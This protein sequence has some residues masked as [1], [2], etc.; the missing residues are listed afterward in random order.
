MKEPGKIAVRGYQVSPVRSFWDPEPSIIKNTLTFDTETEMTP[1][2]RLRVGCY[3]H[4]TKGRTHTG[5]FYDNTVLGSNETKTLTDY[6]KANH[7]NLQTIVGFQNFLARTAR[8]DETAIVGFNLPFD[9]S[10][11][12]AQWQNARGK[13]KDGFTF[14]IGKGLTITVKHLS[15]RKSMYK[16]SGYPGRGPCKAAIVDVMTLGAALSG[17]SHSLASLAKSLGAS[18]QKGTAEH[19]KELT[20]EYLDYLVM[21][22]LTTQEC[23]DILKSKYDS[24]NL[25][26][27]IEAIYSEASLGK[28]YLRSFGVRPTERIDD[29]TTGK[30]MSTYYGGRAEIHIRKQVV[31]VIYT[32]FLSM[33]PT[34]C[35]KMNV[36]KYV[37]AKEIRTY[38]A[39][40][41]VCELLAQAGIEG[42]G[43]LRANGMWGEFI[44]IV[45]ILPTVDI[46]PVRKAYRKGSFNIGVNEASSEEGIWYTL[47]DVIA[48][49]FLTGKVP[50]VLE[51]IGFEPGEPQE[52]LQTLSLMG[53]E[54]LQIDPYSDD[55]YKRLIELRKSEDTTADEKQALKIIAN[56]TC[57]G[58]FVELTRDTVT[59]PEDHIFYSYDGK[60]HKTKTPY[61]ETPGSYFNPVLA[62]AITGAARL[63]LATAERM[64]KDRGIDWALCDTDSMAFTPA[65]QT[66]TDA[67]R[68]GG[69]GVVMND[70]TVAGVQQIVDFFGDLNP[71]SF[72]GSILKLEEVNYAGGQL[73]CFAV[74][75]K[76]YAL[77]TDISIPG[78]QDRVLPTRNAGRL[79]TGNKSR[80]TI[81]K[82]SA[83]GLGYLKRPY[84]A[85]M[86]DTGAPEWVN[87]LWVC[88]L[89][90]REEYVNLNLDSMPRMGFPAQSQ[91]T[92]NTASLYRQLEGYNGK[93]LQSERIRPFGFVA[94]YQ[95]ND[96]NVSALSP[97]YVNNNDSVKAIFDRDT[98][99]PVY[100]EE[101]KTY[102]DVLSY[103]SCHPES[104]FKCGDRTGILARR[105]LE[106]TGIDVIGKESNRI[107][108]ERTQE[109]DFRVQVMIERKGKLIVTRVED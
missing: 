23:F 105:D 92:M 64:G 48:S 77:F 73:Y 108:P 37:T 21:D 93:V 61:I 87:D 39:T 17:R 71:Y 47:P 11:I 31:P 20:T 45:R 78:S 90:C 62:T 97:M 65:T 25:S 34:V 74:S 4:R 69:I 54:H 9:I 13:F 56:S 6:C 91:V 100:R 85:P 66:P 18:Y 88:V 35:T 109:M 103:F 55:F 68:S 49:V 46:L 63:L 7:Y 70:D 106:I 50:T 8:K 16:L 24:Y 26:T 32:D 57:Y 28:A 30:I 27:P 72:P 58:I 15:S 60:P 83:H 52:G 101:C 99:R 44:S 19:G 40:K 51:A 38:D 80:Y 102:K 75:A 5:M 81:R 41:R 22:V 96:I 1:A 76:R 10:R 43:V 104:K 95:C 82:A 86:T 89:N 33:Y 53:N 12:A 42:P 36:W 29:E 2:Q 98:L 94:S 59:E 14:G 3:I 79:A 67:G 84:G 107:D